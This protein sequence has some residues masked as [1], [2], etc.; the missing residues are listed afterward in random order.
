MNKKRSEYTIGNERRDEY[1]RTNTQQPI[2]NERHCCELVRALLVFLFTGFTP[3]AIFCRAFSPSIMAPRG[4]APVGARSQNYE[5][6]FQFSTA[7]NRQ[8]ERPTSNTQHPMTNEEYPS[9]TRIR[10]RSYGATKREVT[11]PSLVEE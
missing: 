1:P 6:I 9:D 7:N 8:K 10:L 5:R 2:S 4:Q 3:S 11:S